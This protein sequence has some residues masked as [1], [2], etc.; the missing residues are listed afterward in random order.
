MLPKFALR[1]SATALT[2]IIA[3]AAYAQTPLNQ[4]APATYEQ[5]PSPFYQAPSPVAAPQQSPAPV[6][7]GQANTY[8]GPSDTTGSQPSGHSMQEQTPSSA[9]EQH[10]TPAYITGG[11]GTAERDSLMAQ[12][13]NYNVKVETAYKSGHYI[14]DAYITILDKN[15]TQMLA[16]MADGPLFYARLAPGKYTVKA[17]YH[18][19]VYERSVDV[20]AVPTTPKRV[21]F[22]WDNP[23]NF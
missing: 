13:N 20:V 18:D 9:S 8:N 23:A 1:L 17:N 16:A 3:S 7:D 22:T 10:T 11:V 5:A 21:V 14:S 6:Y 15:G 2:G 19:K 4:Q 12:A